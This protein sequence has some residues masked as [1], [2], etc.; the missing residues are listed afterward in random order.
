MLKTGVLE[1][2]RE[3]REREILKKT[4]KKLWIKPAKGVQRLFLFYSPLAKKQQNQGSSRYRK[5]HI[6]IV[7]VVGRKTN[8]KPV[9]RKMAHL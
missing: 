3:R 1:Q 7:S 5:K 8:I 6:E 2:Q 9:Q 4:Q